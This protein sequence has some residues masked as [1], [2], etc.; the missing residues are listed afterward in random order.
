MAQTMYRWSSSLVWRPN[1]RLD[2]LPFG[3]G[4]IGY[5]SPSHKNERTSSPGRT[6]LL[7]SL[8]KVNSPKLGELG[9]CGAELWP[10]FLSQVRMGIRSCRTREERILEWVGTAR[11]T[12]TKGRWTRPRAAPK[13]LRVL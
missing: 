10:S 7:D 9:P 8:W 2:V 4:Q 1:V 6:D 11:K 3:V 12:R 5:V 13:R